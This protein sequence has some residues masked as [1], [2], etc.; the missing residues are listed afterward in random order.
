MLAEWLA[1]RITPC[2]RPLRRI[3][4]L[5]ESIA[6]S[7][8]HKRL[9]AAWAPHL[10]ATRAAILRAAGEVSAKRK[11]TVLGSGL[12]LD[13]P[14]A[15]LAA[16]FAEVTLVDVVHP[17]P[18]R[19][20]A[21]RFGNVRLVEADVTGLAAPLFHADA[22]TLADLTA[23]AIDLPEGD[24]DFVVSVN[25]LSQLPVIPC[26]W[27]ARRGTV[28]ES[29]IEALARSIVMGHVEAL[30]RLPGRV[31]LVSDVEHR[32]GDGE[33]TIAAFDPLHGVGLGPADAEWWWDM[34]PHPEI[35]RR[36]DLRARVV[37]TG[38]PLPT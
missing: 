27:L 15:E 25:L 34:A 28:P 38:R 29:E 13:V 18:A 4:Y 3:G 22:G 9:R 19:R 36:H 11:A 24:A 26:R 7:A 10:A 16:A 5:A 6:T 17:R 14:L 21:A 1:Q 2:S 20:A 8:R 37:A 30:A 32:L 31:L 23:K 35:D 33:R 12:L